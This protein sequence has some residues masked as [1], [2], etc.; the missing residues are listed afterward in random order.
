MLYYVLIAFQI[1][2]NQ[3]KHAR[4]IAIFLSGVKKED[5]EKYEE[6]ETN[7]EGAYLSDGMADS[8]QI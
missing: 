3:L 4:R 5:K 2:E 7:F 6:T 8:A 1:E